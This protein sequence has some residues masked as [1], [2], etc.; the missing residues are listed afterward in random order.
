MIENMTSGALMT[1]NGDTWVVGTPVAT[2]ELDCHGNLLFMDTTPGS[3]SFISLTDGDLFASLTNQFAFHDTIPGTDGASDVPTYEELGIGTTGNNDARRQLQNE[4]RYELG[5]PVVDVELTPEQ[6]D[7]IVDKGLSELRSRSSIPYKR[8]FFFMEVHSETQV[9]YLTNKI[10]GMNKIVDILGVYRTTS[11]F[12]SSAHGAGVYGQI[13][14]QHMYNMGTFDLLSYHIMSEYT[15]LME[16][17]F[18]ARITFSWNEQSRQLFLH[19]RFPMNERTVCIEAT[20]ERSEQDMLTDRY[21]RAWMR[22]YCLAT[23]RLILA[24]TRGKFSTLPGASGSVTLNASELRQASQQEIEACLQE[25]EDYVVD[26]PDEFGM[27]TQ[28]VFG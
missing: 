5:Y 10:Q 9:Y 26:K 20:T 25:I 23:A 21:I 7:Y 24:E 3:L 15:K 27:G 11:S 1:W 16:M 19:H 12:L 17:L 22:R 2:V 4:I 14:L 6:L 8:G 13:V 18:A 28:F